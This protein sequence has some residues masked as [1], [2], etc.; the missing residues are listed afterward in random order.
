M[1]ISQNVPI[2]TKV[3]LPIGTFWLIKALRTG[4]TC[5][6]ASFLRCV[7]RMYVR[8]GQTFRTSVARV[9]EQLEVLNAR[10]VLIKTVLIART[11]CTRNSI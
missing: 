2:E 1:L 8:D 10:T 3:G 4:P 5:H 7:I 6:V 9:F 11:Y